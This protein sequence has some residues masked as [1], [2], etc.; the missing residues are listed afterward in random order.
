MQQS[1]TAHAHQFST[2][3]CQE[4]SRRLADLCWMC[5]A[6]KTNRAP[7]AMI[8]QHP[9][10]AEQ[11]NRKR[12]NQLDIYRTGWV[13][14]GAAV[15]QVERDKKDDGEKQADLGTKETPSAESSP[16]SGPLR[17]QAVLSQRHRCGSRQRK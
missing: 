4:R 1:V 5:D 11:A 15:G 14:G 7:L 12:R 3:P 16:P 10:H 6:M 13:D 9:I 2:V 17:A 8:P